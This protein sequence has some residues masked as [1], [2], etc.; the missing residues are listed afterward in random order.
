MSFGIPVRNGLAIGLL[1][2]TFLSSLRVGGR[3][4]MFLN[5]VNTTSLDPRVTF[6]RGTTAT[7]VGSNGLIQ[8]AAINAPRFDYDPVTLAPKG[9]LIEEQRVNLLRYSEQFDNVLWGKANVTIAA[10]VETSPDGTLNA[11]KLVDTAING[12]HY[13]EQSVTV[14]SGSSYTFSMYVKADGRDQISLRYTGG[15]LWVGGSSPQI[16]FSLLTE[17]ITIVS[18]G[19]AITASSLIPVGGGWYRCSMTATVAMPGT[20]GSRIQLYKNGT[21]IY[22]GDGVSGAYLFGAQTETGPFPTSYIPTVASQV[23]RSA[24]AATMTGTNFSSWYNQP[25]GTL[26]A[27]FSGTG[28]YAVVMN[29]ATNNNYTGILNNSTTAIRG[30]IAVAAAARSIDMPTTA[31]AI[32]KTA[33]AYKVNDLAGST[34]G[35]TVVTNA[36]AA[37]PSLTQM[38]I[39]TSGS[40]GFLNGHIRSIAYYNTR[41]ANATLRALTT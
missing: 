33:F 28:V 36:T 41:L 15:I 11:D 5:F 17:T 18:G 2:S 37:I 1:A 16:V 3:P 34:N 19:A 7:F 40:F 8:T 31:G 29:D 4:A 22:T 35:G 38:V 13:A 23:T 24:D 21:A 9:L 14:V 20:A 27:A 10:N 30:I 26:L 12:E 6:T 25:Q 39:G 32:N